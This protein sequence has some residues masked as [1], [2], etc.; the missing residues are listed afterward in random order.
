MYTNE[1][2]HYL[3]VEKIV[4][5][6]LKYEAEQ[7][8]SESIINK[9]GDAYLSSSEL[10]AIINHRKRLKSGYKKLLEAFKLLKY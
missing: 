10:K 3:E 8:V 9:R 2:Y 7:F 5:A 4:I 6:K 1:R